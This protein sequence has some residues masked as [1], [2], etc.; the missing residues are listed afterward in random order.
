L[1]I[2]N[3]YKIT[4]TSAYF[5]PDLSGQPKSA[6]PEVNRA[7]DE[8]CYLLKLGKN[9]LYNWASFK[10]Q[11]IQMNSS[12][13]STCRGAF[14]ITQFII[15]IFFHSSSFASTDTF[16]KTFQSSTAALGIPTGTITWQTSVSLIVPVTVMPVGSIEPF[17]IVGNVSNSSTGLGSLTYNVATVF[18]TPTFNTGNATTSQ[19]YDSSIT[20]TGGKVFVGAANTW[21]IRALD[22]VSSGTTSFTGTIAGVGATY[23]SSVQGATTADWFEPIGISNQQVTI[24]NRVLSSSNHGEF[25]GTGA[26]FTING[27]FQDLAAGTDTISFSSLANYL[28]YG[29]LSGFNVNDVIASTSAISLSVPITSVASVP[30]PASFWLFGAGILGFLGLKRRGNIE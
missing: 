18:G 15:Y 7:A 4:S 25:T 23:T 11:E 2:N 1:I 21:S 12:N 28:I 9:C 20:V 24:E 29:A 22:N 5:Y 14:L 27:F 8:S 17:T 30:V 6:I 13:R 16:T 3:P 26:S 10:L 19:P